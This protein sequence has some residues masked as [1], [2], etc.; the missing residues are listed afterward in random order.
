MVS[1]RGAAFPL[2]RGARCFLPAF[3]QVS[4]V[5]VIY[6][7]HTCESEPVCGRVQLNCRLELPMVRP[8]RLCEIPYF[9]AFLASLEGRRQRNRLKK[10][11][12]ARSSRC[13]IGLTRVIN[14]TN[15]DAVHQGLGAWQ[16]SE[17][18]QVASGCPSPKFVAEAASG[19]PVTGGL[20]LW[21]ARCQVSRTGLASMEGFDDFH[22]GLPGKA[23]QMRWVVPSASFPSG[24]KPFLIARTRNPQAAPS[25][26]APGVE[27]IGPINDRVGYPPNKYQRHLPFLPAPAARSQ[28]HSQHVLRRQVSRCAQG[29]MGARPSRILTD[30][31]PRFPAML[32]CVL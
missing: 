15:P 25:Q 18:P 29:E 7:S 17:K 32:Y 3:S 22:S 8:L 19:R 20:E 16:L 27:I 1:G 31:S 2:A 30:A 21:G 9:F 12:V 10:A 13:D 28:G 4:L 11:A 24:P 5:A 26:E 23:R 6:G 14:S